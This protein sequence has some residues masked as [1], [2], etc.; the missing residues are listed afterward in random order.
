MNRF[1][2]K[3][4][5]LSLSIILFCVLFGLINVVKPNI[6]YNQGE[7]RPFGINYSKNT[8]TPLWLVTIFLAVL[9]YLSMLY[10]KTLK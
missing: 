1:F 3:K 8:V 7:I 6:L 2:M 4:N 9:S 5:V 10:M